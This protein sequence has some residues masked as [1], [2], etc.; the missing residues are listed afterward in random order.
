MIY[1]LSHKNNAL[2]ILQF[3]IFQKKLTFYEILLYRILDW[4]VV[5]KSSILTLKLL[6]VLKKDFEIE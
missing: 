4:Y 3:N 5:W 6:N 1:F 2:K